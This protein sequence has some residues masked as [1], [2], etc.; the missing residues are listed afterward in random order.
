MKPQLPTAFLIPAIIVLVMAIVCF[1]RIRSIETRVIRFFFLMLRRLCEIFFLPPRELASTRAVTRIGIT[2]KKTQ[3]T[4]TRSTATTTTRTRV[5]RRLFLVMILGILP[6]VEGACSV[7]DRHGQLQN[8][9]NVLPYGVNYY[10]NLDRLECIGPHSCREWI[11]TGCSE[12][13]CSNSFS[14]QDAQLID[15]AIVSC[16][17]Q[18]SCYD[19]HFFQA[20][21]ITCGPQDDGNHRH[22]FCARAVIETDDKL[23]CA[24]PGACVADAYENRMTVLVGAKGQVRCGNMVSEELS[25][26]YLDIEIQHGRQACFERYGGLNRGCAVLC[27]N[28]WDCDEKSIQFRVAQK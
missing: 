15:N 4:V 26:Q 8:I 2:R 10:A 6:A 13:E 24:G 23:L 17:A 20:H 12:V 14:C 21:E 3:T 7:K 28:D 1:H 16:L 19:T 5:A 25:C 18:Q 22:L 27:V 9:N 11:I